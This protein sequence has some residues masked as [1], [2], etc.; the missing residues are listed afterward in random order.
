VPIQF[1][2]AV[3]GGEVEVPTI[4]GRV[5]LKVPPETQS[6]KL[7]RLRGKGVGSQRHGQGDLLCRVAVETPVRLTSEQ[8]DVLKQFQDLLAQ[9]GT[10]HNPKASSWFGKVKQFFAN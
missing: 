3:L 8:K 7:F 5:S 6:G 1:F 9:G 4:D 10:V 2:T